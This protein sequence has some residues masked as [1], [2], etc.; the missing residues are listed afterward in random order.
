MSLTSRKLLTKIYIDDQP[1]NKKTKLKSTLEHNL[2]KQSKKT[3]KYDYKKSRNDIVKFNNK[4][5]N[6]DA[7]NKIKEEENSNKFPII[8]KFNL[9]NIKID[10]SIKNDEI[11]EAQINKKIIKLNYKL[12]ESTTEDKQYPLRELKKGLNGSGWQSDRFCQYPQYIYI[13]FIQPTLI[14]R[15]ELVL[16]EKNIPT[17]IK[18]YTFIPKT[19]DENIS[20]YQNVKY[21][22]IGYIK[23]DSNEK[24]NYQLRE[25][26]KINVNCKSLFFKIELERN[27]LNSYNL[28]NQVG[29]M[30]L[31]FKGEYLPYVGG[32]TENNNLILKIALKKNFLNDGDLENICG[33]KLT[34]LKKQ[35]IFNIQIEDYR[36][37]KEI[38]K[39]IEQIRL[40]GKKI[41]DLESEKNIA[42]NNGDLSKAIEMKN[43]I[44]KL[45]INIHNI[46]NLNSPNSMEKNMLNDRITRFSNIP[47]LDLNINQNNAKSYDFNKLN[48]SNKNN[49]SLSYASYNNNTVSQDVYASYDETMLPNVLKKLNNEETQ[50]EEELLEKGELE[51]VSP[52][53]LKEF[54]L[55]NKS[56]GEEN[57]RKIFSEQ[58]SWKEEGLILLMEKIDEILEGNHSNEMISILIKLSIRL[59]EDSHP[60]IVIKALE[61]LKALFEF[62]KKN[63]IKLNIDKDIKDDILLKVKK[64]L[65]EVNS[66]IRDKSVSLYCYILSS[67][68]YNYNN[69]VSELANEEIKENNKNLV[70]MNCFILG[71]LDIFINLLNNFEDA[72]KMKITD[73]DSFPS[74]LVMNFLI[75]NISNNKA[76]IRI[77][78]RKAINLFSKIFEIEKYKENLE[79][80]EEKELVALIE[81]NPNLQKY[82]PN[83]KINNNK[84]T[85]IL[86]SKNLLINNKDMLN[87]KTVNLKLNFN[88][89]WKK[90]KRIFLKSKFINSNFDSKT[91]IKNKK[92]VKNENDNNA[93]NNNN[94]LNDETNTLNENKEKKVK[95]NHCKIELKENEVLANHYISN[96]PM[97][98]KCEKCSLNLEVKNLNKHRIEE[99]NFKN[100]YQLCN[101]CNESILKKD[102]D[103]HIKNKCNLNKGYVKCPLCHQD[104]EDTDAGFYQHL[105]IK[106]CPSQKIRP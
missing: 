61:I 63:N 90:S 3:E 6:N 31:D 27:H 83:I 49:N 25:S 55:I 36:K 97:F 15:I 70:K 84:K 53:I 89:N 1:N 44:D 17:K 67:G 76:E 48:D 34:E 96:C 52:E 74:N 40:Y 32:K 94:S 102:Y 12:I 21:E 66:K 2:F 45:K 59:I 8:P 18:F 33:R 91:N 58:V 20:N 5:D 13:Q 100:E 39:K 68:L 87:L 29:L 22:F 69:L 4:N 85:N 41:F 24:T 78:V 101:N 75:L 98:T 38:K 99:C 64:K 30:K 51:Q 23:A 65:E 92:E 82:F 16:H 42:I 54:N 73:K 71:K 77:K 26:R 37:C 106:S 95:C 46:D 35:M 104:I 103:L 88:K 93:N 79:N 80:I 11:K 7:I 43:L 86:N 10:E 72:V 81:E 19:K 62:I 56:I 9:N 105:V 57:L 14:K 50:K 60:F 47:I 28:F